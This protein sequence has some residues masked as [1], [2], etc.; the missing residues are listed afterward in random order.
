MIMAALQQRQ[1]RNEL[2]D[3]LHPH[4]M[5][6]RSAAALEKASCMFG[7]ASEGPTEATTGW[8]EAIMHKYHERVLTAN[9]H[10]LPVMGATL[11]GTIIWELGQRLEQAQRVPAHP[12]AGLQCQPTAPSPP[13][14]VNKGG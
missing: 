9:D 1:P 6:Q 12:K 13:A 14:E 2:Y 8:Q 11:V 5:P 4:W 7:R 10:Q 3:S